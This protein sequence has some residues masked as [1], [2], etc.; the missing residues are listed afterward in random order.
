MPTGRLTHE[1]ARQ[2]HGIRRF[3]DEFVHGILGAERAIELARNGGQRAVR[4]LVRR[5][6]AHVELGHATRPGP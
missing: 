3:R 5:A 6:A 2:I 1:H 4:R